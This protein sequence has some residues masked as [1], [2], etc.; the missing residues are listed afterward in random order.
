M[1][2]VVVCRSECVC[3]CPSLAWLSKLPSDR[4]DSEISVGE[5]GKLG[6]AVRE[7]LAVEFGD[8]K[9]FPLRASVYV[10]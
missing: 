10:K 4:R 1:E 3:V 7:F 5:S 2:V 6:K 9:V 8:G